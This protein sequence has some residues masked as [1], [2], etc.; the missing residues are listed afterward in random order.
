MKKTIIPPDIAAKALFYSDRTCCV[1]RARGKPV[2]IH[3]ID[4]NNSNNNINNLAVLCLDCHTDTQI[5]GGFHRKLDADQVILYRDDWVSIVSRERSEALMS[6]EELSSSHPNIEMT[7]TTLEILR[8][9]KQYELLAVEYDILGNKELRDKYIELALKQDPSDQTEIFLRHLQDKIQLVDS[10]KIKR[11]I[12]RKKKY[13]DWSQLARLYAD[14]GDYENAITCYCKTISDDLKK[15]NIFAPAYYLKELSKKKLFNPLFEKAFRK[16]TKENNLWWQVR[17]LQE[18][19]WHTELE[20]LLIS[21][22]D[23][24]EHSDDLMLKEL[25]YEITGDKARLLEAT[26]EI[27][28]SSRTVV[29]GKQGVIAA[30]K[31]KKPKRLQ[32]TQRKRLKP[33]P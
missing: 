15:G 1:C 26:K 31:R 23:E 27:A 14:I 7:T 4:E 32:L 17:S 24:I 21:K 5:S 29:M 13:E 10:K 3:H 20:K 25:L 30:S 11:E 19:G 22:K 8:E 12:A 33:K 9:N 6:T 2:Q 16:Y 18:L 28:K